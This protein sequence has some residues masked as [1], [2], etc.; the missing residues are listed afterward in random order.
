MGAT[1]F[2]DFTRDN[3]RPVTVEYSYSAGSETT[4]SPMFGACGGDGCEVSIVDSWPNTTSFERLH[5]CKSDLEVDR[6]KRWLGLIAP[7]S[8]LLVDILIWIQQRRARLTDAE[9]SAWKGGS[10]SITSMNMS[11]SKRIISNE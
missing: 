1:F 6:Q 11:R 5:K 2:Q 10:P 7:G 3:G 4:Y 9:P 8:I